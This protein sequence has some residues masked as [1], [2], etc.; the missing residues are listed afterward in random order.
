MFLELNKLSHHTDT[1]HQAIRDAGFRLVNLSYYEAPVRTAGP[2]SRHQDQLV[3]MHQPVPVVAG[4]GPPA[5]TA[6]SP[7]PSSSIA[8]GA[9]AAAATAAAGGAGTA[10]ASGA[11]TT[12][13]MLLA[14][15]GEFIPVDSV[16]GD[17]LPS[18]V[19]ISMITHRWR[20]AQQY[21]MI[22]APESNPAFAQMIQSLQAV[23]KASGARTLPN[24]RLFF[25]LCFSSPCSC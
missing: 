10:A 20:V 11:T 21:N 8:G 18:N 1:W 3:V 2:W 23:T 6:V 17:F 15:L 13:T 22:G 25:D 4:A 14:H 9:T 24:S 12:T 7:A 16:I 5:S 19:L